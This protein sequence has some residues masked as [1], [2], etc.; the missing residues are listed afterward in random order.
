MIASP[1]SLILLN[2]A[3][4]TTYT[5]PSYTEAI[6]SYT[7]IPNN[8]YVC[9]VPMPRDNIYCAYLQCNILPNMNTN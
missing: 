5:E 3:T 7:Q 9:N 1:A 4:T 2:I 6:S 8:P